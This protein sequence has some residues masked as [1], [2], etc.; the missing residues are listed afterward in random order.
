MKLIHHVI[1]FFLRF[2][3]PLSLPEDI[4]I[5]LGIPLS[6]FLCFDEVIA[7][8]IHP[9]MKPS[10][11]EKFMPRTEA[12]KAFG[13]ALRK[14]SFQNLSLFF[15]HFNGGWMSFM[16]QFDEQSRL[17]RLYIQ[18]KNLRMKHEIPI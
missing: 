10:N 3:Y 17:R 8:L 18:H 6:N 4:A 5:A 11:L 9:Q 7:H 15:Y 2:R 13:N 14:E 16:L 1:R 12:E